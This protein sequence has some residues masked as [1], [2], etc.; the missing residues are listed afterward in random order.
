MNSVN[1]RPALVESPSDE[2]PVYQTTLSPS[3]VVGSW[4]LACAG[5]MPTSEF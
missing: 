3:A 4:G 2:L 1:V 5:G